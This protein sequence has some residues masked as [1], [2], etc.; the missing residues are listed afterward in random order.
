[1]SGLVDIPAELRAEGKL[2]LVVALEGR[3]VII[4]R[5]FVHSFDASRVTAP[6]WY[7][8]RLASDLAAAQD[9]TEAF[10]RRRAAQ[11]PAAPAPARPMAHPRAAAPFLH[12]HFAEPDDDA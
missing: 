4:E 2:F 9:R 1:M 11:I 8:E 10:A 6:D 12:A 3:L 7:A 5:R